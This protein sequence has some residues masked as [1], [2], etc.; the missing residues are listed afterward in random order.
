MIR[1]DFETGGFPLQNLAPVMCICADYS[2]Q[3]AYN[4][5]D[6]VNILKN[7]DI[8]SCYGVW[9]GKKTTD[10]F[11]LD[12]KIYIALPLPPENSKEIDNA[13][14]IIVHMEAGQSFLKVSYTVGGT[15]YESKSKELLDYIK[16]AG[17]RF[18]LVFD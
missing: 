17:V 6:L 13:S 15:E 4:K 1:K 14:E 8:R 7:Y 10:S 3:M 16:K 18:S 5:F 2:V 12:P 9:P 11:L